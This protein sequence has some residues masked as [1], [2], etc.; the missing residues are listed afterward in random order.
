MQ[1]FLL[2]LVLR[3]SSF[4]VAAKASSV[5]AFTGLER[6]LPAWPPSGPFGL[7]LQRVFVDPLIHWDAHHY[8]WIATRGYSA[9]DSTTAFYP[10]FPWSAKLLSFLGVDP[11]A[12]L[13]LVSSLAGLAFLYVFERLARLDLPVERARSAALFLLIFPISMVLF[14]PYTE[15]MFFLFAALC[16]YTARKKRWWQSARCAASKDCCDGLD[17]LKRGWGAK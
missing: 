6:S 11:A 7:W 2:W 12:G 14:I 8:L 3:I 15:G 1:I 9:G 13:V 16:F 10:L 5:Q 17:G 4:L